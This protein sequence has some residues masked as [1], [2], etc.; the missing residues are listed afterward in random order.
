[1]AEIVQ[2]KK[3]L[4]IKIFDTFPQIEESFWKKHIF[5]CY[6]MFQEKNEISYRIGQLQKDQI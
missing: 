1:M 3:S 2:V 5:Q 6:K 4:I